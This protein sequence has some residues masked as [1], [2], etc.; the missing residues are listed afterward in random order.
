MFC[1]EI[2]F[3]KWKRSRPKTTTQETNIKLLNKNIPYSISYIQSLL[4]F[5]NT[6][7]LHR[8]INKPNHI[9]QINTQLRNEGLL[10][11]L[12]YVVIDYALSRSFYLF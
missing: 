6:Y 9:I 4:K 8:I 5:C 2:F 10:F 7:N 3:D 12:S 1:N 11:L